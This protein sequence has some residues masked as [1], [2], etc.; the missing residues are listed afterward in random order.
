[1]KIVKFLVFMIFLCLIGVMIYFFIFS[2]SYQKSMKARVE[3]YMGNYKEALTL[4]NEAYELDKYNKM[5]FS[6]LTQS[7]IA[8]KMIYFID[9]ANK[10]LKDIDQISQKENI[11]QSDRMKI[12]VI[13][14]VMIERY[15]R[16]SPTILTDKDLYEKCTKYYQ[17]FQKIE[18]ELF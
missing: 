1:M 7:K 9:D 3:Y 4:A 12:K 13:C 8:F 11:T 16:L 14:N 18:D 17:K 6:I 10:Y 5:A 15:K 2:D